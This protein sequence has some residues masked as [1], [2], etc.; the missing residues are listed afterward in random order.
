MTFFPCIEFSVGLPKE[1]FKSSEI[2]KTYSYPSRTHLATSTE[3]VSFHQMLAKVV[4][5]ARIKIL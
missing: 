2:K 5:P 1:G 4:L 3:R